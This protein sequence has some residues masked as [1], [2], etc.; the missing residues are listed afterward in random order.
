MRGDVMATLSVKQ[1][2]EHFGVGEGTILAWIRSGQLRAMDVARHQG[3][4]RPK[5][6]AT[7]SAVAAF[8]ELRQISP[9]PDP[10][11]RGRKSNDGVVE[12]YK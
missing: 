11:R 12:F 4:G 9:T 7:E 2:R 8:E 3:G 5:W 6:R 1:L 10:V